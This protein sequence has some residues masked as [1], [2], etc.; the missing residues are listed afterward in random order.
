LFTIFSP[1]VN[2]ALHISKSFRQRTSIYSWIFPV[3]ILSG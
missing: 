2:E 1:A 3:D